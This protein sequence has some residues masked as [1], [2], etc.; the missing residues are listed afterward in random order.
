[1]SPE[2]QVLKY[3]QRLESARKLILEESQ[4]EGPALLDSPERIAAFMLARCAGL[5][6]EKFWVC[7]LDRQNR[8]I[9]CVEITS[10][11]ATSCLVHPREVFRPAVLHSA[12]AIICVHNHPSGDPSRSDA[13]IKVTRLISAAAKVMGIDLL[14]H[15][16]IGRKTVDP[17][18]L[19]YYSFSET[20]LL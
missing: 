11:T 3:D 12:S 9:E 18:N 16:I 17:Q 14:D 4:K 13:D 10:G 19:G 7:C 6:I 2:Q 1:M 5:K 15:V 8:L 20:G